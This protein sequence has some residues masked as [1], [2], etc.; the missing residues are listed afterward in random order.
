MLKTVL[1]LKPKRWAIALTPR[2]CRESSKSSN[3]LKQLFTAGT[4]L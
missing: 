1:L 3:I 4:G 2:G